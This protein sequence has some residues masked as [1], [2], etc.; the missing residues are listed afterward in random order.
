MNAPVKFMFDTPFDA[1]QAPPPVAHGEVELLK[2]NHKIEL[3]RLQSEALQQ[4]LEEGRREAQESLERQLLAALEQLV[5]DKQQ[6]KEDINAKL[7]DARAS[8]IRF[9]M[10]IAKKLASSLLARYPQ[11]HIETFFR[12]ALAL[13]PEKTALR[14]HVAP[15]LATA[16]EPR[17][18]AVMERNGQKN[19][20]Q[21]IADET[22]EGVNLRLLW[23]DGG[24]EHDTD[25]IFATIEQMIETSLYADQGSPTRQGLAT[26]GEAK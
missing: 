26:T 11:E 19:A 1:P 20:L 14:L 9:A 25:Q 12:D 5:R 8:S 18:A 24:I 7:Q 21:I 10:T 17:L 2:Q 16:M 23:A 15:H 22:I 4:G 6:T 13:L 3:E